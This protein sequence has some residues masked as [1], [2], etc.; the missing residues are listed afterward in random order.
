MTDMENTPDGEI[1]IDLATAGDVVPWLALAER[2]TVLFGT[3]PG[4]EMI[5][6]RKI[7][8]RQAYCARWRG[9]AASFLGAALVGGNSDFRWIRWLAVLPE[10]RHKGI[11]KM[12]VQKAVTV[13]G[14]APV[15]VDTFCDDS[16]AATAARRLYE[17][18]GFCPTEIVSV[19]GLVRQRY[20][21]Q[22]RCAD[23]DLST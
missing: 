1:V 7:L 10:H 2:M 12:L 4:F 18:C 16:A 5:L 21:R 23:D 8:Q 19:D 3:M 22:R 6:N 14:T 9:S 15:Y 17:S 13:S 20:S 11:G